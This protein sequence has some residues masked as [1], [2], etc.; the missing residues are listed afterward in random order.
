MQRDLVT[1]VVGDELV[2]YDPSRGAL[3]LLNP[4]AAKIYLMVHGRRVNSAIVEEL[5]K[6]HPEFEGLGEIV[7]EESLAVLRAAGLLHGES[8]VEMSRRS[9]LRAAG[10]L[11]PAA[12]SVGLSAPASALSCATPLTSC[13]VNGHPGVCVPAGTSVQDICCNLGLSAPETLFFSFPFSACP[14]GS[15]IDEFQ[16]VWDCGTMTGTFPETRCIARP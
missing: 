15:A 16:S 6:R 9:V 1:Q 13:S 7:V 10:I 5:E 12:L 11:L 2:V 3:G 4:T 8:V 14:M